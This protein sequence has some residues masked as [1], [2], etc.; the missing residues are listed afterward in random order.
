M[1]SKTPDIV[2]SHIIF[3]NT[4]LSNFA[5]AKQFEILKRL[6]QGRA[7]ICKAVSKEGEADIVSSEPSS[8]L[9]H[10]SRIEAVQS[11]IKQKWLAIPED[12]VETR[13]TIQELE[14]AVAFGE[15]VGAKEAESMA[16]ALTRKWV[17]ASDDKR[18]RAFA[19][20]KGIRLTSTLG[21]LLKAT[22]LQIISCVMA[23][24]L[25]AFM[26]DEGYRSPLPYENGIS[27]YLSRQRL[28]T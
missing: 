3:D 9:R 13:D 8:E 11:A 25:H 17:F 26:V 4:V 1:I 7:F 20:A 6:Y 21:I 22:E 18:A 10:R 23:D 15:R 27:K 19:K 2:A 28:L 16:I 12:A 5:R 24:R 14:L